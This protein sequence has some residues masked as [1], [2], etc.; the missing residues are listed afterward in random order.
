MVVAVRGMQGQD[1]DADGGLR[2]SVPTDRIDAKPVSEPVLVGQASSRE[3][4]Y[5]IGVI[6][7]AW[8]IFPFDTMQVRKDRERIA[9]MR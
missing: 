5:A 1:R 4:Y 2:R 3:D 6:P 8:T 7:F 9:M